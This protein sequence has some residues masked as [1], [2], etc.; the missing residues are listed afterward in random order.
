MGHLYWELAVQGIH[1]L[2]FFLSSSTFYL[3]F[4]PL[5]TPCFPQLPGV[6]WTL[7]LCNKDWPGVQLFFFFPGHT[8]RGLSYN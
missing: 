1:E 5:W 4:F 6:A 8:V 7:A 3:L 2:F